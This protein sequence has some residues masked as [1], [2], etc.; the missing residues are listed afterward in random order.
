MSWRRIK[1]QYAGACDGCGAEILEGDYI[2]WLRGAPPRC[3]QCG[4]GDDT[5][6]PT[7]RQERSTGREREDQAGTIWSPKGREEQIQNLN[8]EVHE[9]QRQVATLVRQLGALRRAVGC[10][11]SSLEEGEL[12][13][14]ASSALHEHDRAA[15]TNPIDQARARARE[16]V[17][18]E[19]DQ[20]A[21][22]EDVPF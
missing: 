12:H 11:A 20:A 6:E 14:G 4:A 7:T 10:V 13:D 3:E 17:A 18:A 5:A 16:T 19:L 8:R 1:T 22:D 21:A 2:Y 15:S 9:L